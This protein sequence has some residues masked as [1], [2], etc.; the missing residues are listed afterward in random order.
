MS[1]QFSKR[2][3][4]RRTSRRD[5]LGSVCAFSSAATAAAALQPARV[6]S[7][8]LQSLDP[9][10]GKIRYG[11][12]GSLW[13]EWPNGNLRMSSDVHQIAADA[14]RVGLQGIEPYSSQ[15]AEWLDK[16][17]ALRKVCNDAGVA[18]IDVGDMPTAW[19]AKQPEGTAA[20]GGAA[21]NPWIEAE[22]NARLI[23]RM[24][25][26]AR[27]F[28]APCGCD[29]WK[30]NM[31]SRPQGGPSEDQLKRLAD[32]LNEIGRQTIGHGVRL[33]PHPHI[34]GPMEREHE[35]RTVLERTDPRF[36][37]ITLDTGHLTLGGM[38][39]VKIVSEY[40]S[41]IAEVHLKDTYPRF[42][43]NHATPTREEYHRAGIYRNLGAGGV[44]F[45]AVMKILRARQF[46]GW[47]VLDLDAPRPGDGTGT[48]EENL[49]AN[50]RYLRDVL[51]VKL[52]GRGKKS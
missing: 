30:T 40:F 20:A 1:S 21:P 44:D 51:H 24:A 37:W 35:V 16:P 10:D 42:R 27:D 2:R 43:G 46:D 48:I 28:L 38:D 32:T 9:A 26:F 8:A 17:L 36:V 6:W 39:A 45:P 4:F 41:R 15:V 33:A 50:V 12:T 47:V 18:L 7:E 19:R 22:G 11:V 14:A 31:G 49:E 23:S 3:I 5:F 34:W 13:G 52:P 29:H 25:S